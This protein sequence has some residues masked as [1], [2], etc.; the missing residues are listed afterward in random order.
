MRVAAVVAVEQLLAAGLLLVV[1]EHLAVDPVEHLAVARLV[2]VEHL[3]VERCHLPAEQA[4]VVELR[5]LPAE[6]SPT[7]PDPAFLMLM[8]LTGKLVP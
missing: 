7:A 5:H 2:V 3:A 4:L 8:R 1:V 6:C